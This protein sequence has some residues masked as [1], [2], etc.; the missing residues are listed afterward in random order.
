MKVFENKYVNIDASECAQVNEVL[1]SNQL[2][3]MSPTIVQYERKLATYFNVQ[4]ALAVTNGTTAIE[5]ALR[6]AGV[7]NGDEVITTPLGPVMTPLPIVAVGATPVFVD[8]ESAGSFNISL[9]DLKNKITSKTR[10]VISVPM[11]GYPN[12]MREIKVLCAENNIILIEDASHCHGAMVHNKFQGT[13]GDM[14]V[15]STQERKLIGTGEGGFIL[16]DDAHLAARVQELRNFGKPV[17]QEFIDKGLAD[18]YGHMFGLNYRLNAFAAGVG[19][20]QI[21]KLEKKIQQ[22]T[23]HAAYYNECLPLHYLRELP[24]MSN[25][26]PNYYAI[27]YKVAH[28][29]YSASDLG[30]K[31]FTYGIVSD[32][33]RFRYDVLYKMPLFKQYASVCSNAETL[34]TSIITLPTHEGLSGQDLQFIIETVNCILA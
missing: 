29:R 4:H 21:G 2:S 28:P 24:F 1:L 6:A 33:Y 19:I 14:G 12:D 3:G 11:W 34:A 10:A 20:A 18:Q 13:I 32:T 26:R 17:R 7:G 15:F 8:C 23:K 22:R 25:G 31:L 16:T 9:T 27:V 5:I 30:A